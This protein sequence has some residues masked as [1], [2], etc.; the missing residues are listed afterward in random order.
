MKAGVEKYK[1]STYKTVIEDA[2]RSVEA[3][4][5]DGLLRMEVEFPPLGM[6][7]DGYKDS[8]DTYIDANIQFGLYLAR[9]L[10][11]EGKRAR[12]LLPDNAELERA[13]KKFGALLEQE[14]RLS[15]G[16]LDEAKE[17]GFG[18][19]ASMFGL[20]NYKEVKAAAQATAAASEVFVVV[21]TST[22]DLPSVEEYCLR[23][24]TE[25]PVIL[26]NL[27]LDTLRADL[28]LL[29]FPSKDVQYRFLS[30]FQP[31]FYIRPRDYS[32]TVN[33]S[34][35]ILS[36]AGSLMRIYPGPWQVML[37]Q[38]AGEYVCVAEA[39]RRYTLGQFKEELMAAVGLDTELEGSAMAFLRRGYKR[40]TWWEDDEK[41][42]LSDAW[43]S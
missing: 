20:G 21:N 15:M 41:E 13:T 38:A 30:Q 3:G 34:P 18:S 40:S 14:A 33:V 7:D 10:A 1:P 27:E 11:S 12:L 37:K 19:V 2:T 43:R 23:Y 29:G 35:F 25:K 9:K 31:V 17:G 26:F 8:S 42:E 22:V 28:G 6:S 16:S 24:A 5:A 32:K 4:I 36:Y 39:P